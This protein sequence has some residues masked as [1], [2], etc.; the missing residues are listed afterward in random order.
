[1]HEC[2]C[3]LDGQQDGSGAAA[4]RAASSRRTRHPPVI[5]GVSGSTAPA[6]EDSVLRIGVDDLGE[7]L[8]RDATR[9]CTQGGTG[10]NTQWSAY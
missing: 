4:D 1:M 2:T 10:S 8:T 5:G 7:T 6:S 3:R 9:E